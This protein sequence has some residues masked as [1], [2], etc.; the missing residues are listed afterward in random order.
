MRSKFHNF[1]HVRGGVMG[2]PSWKGWGLVKD[3]PVNRITDRHNQKHYLSATSLTGGN[4]SHLL[5]FIMIWHLSSEINFF[6]TKLDFQKTVDLF[7][8]LLIFFAFTVTMRFN[9]IP[10]QNSPLRLSN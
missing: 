4:N 10:Q 1:E 7:N 6:H 8:I 9:F 2:F 5:T 3:P